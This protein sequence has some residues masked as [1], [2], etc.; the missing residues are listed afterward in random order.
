[1][2]EIFRQLVKLE[3]GRDAIH[4]PGLGMGFERTQ[5]HLASVFLVIGAFIRHPQHRHLGQARDRFG[6]DV[7]M[8]T[9]MQR[10]V[11]PAMRPTSWPHIPAQFTIISHSI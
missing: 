10:H 11:D 3:I 4:R 5:H 1:M 7:E 2:V 9:G 6:H 8:F